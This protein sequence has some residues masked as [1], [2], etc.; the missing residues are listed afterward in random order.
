M[1]SRAMLMCE[2][3]QFRITF[4]PI[5]RYIFIRTGGTG[6]LSKVPAC[7][8]HPLLRCP[9][10]NIRE[11]CVVWHLLVC[12]SLWHISARCDSTFS[13]CPK[14]WDPR[15]SFATILDSSDTTRCIRCA[16]D[17]FPRV[18]DIQRNVSFPQIVPSMHIPGHIASATVS[19][20]RQSQWRG[21]SC[22][23]SITA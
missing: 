1:T 14:L 19:Q 20:S 18:P 10:S 4:Q 3:L 12:I 23:L 22:P 17:Q 15:P 16:E 21:H 5:H 7:P 11:V 2:M 6:L 9:L 13:L 8:S